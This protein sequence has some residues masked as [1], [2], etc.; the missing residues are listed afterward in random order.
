VRAAIGERAIAA[1]ASVVDELITASA[2]N[3]RARPSAR[4]EMSTATT[5]APRAAPI[6][7]AAS[8]T[9]P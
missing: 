5:R 6:I 8:P 9:P 7:V 2:P 3:R 4:S 1:T